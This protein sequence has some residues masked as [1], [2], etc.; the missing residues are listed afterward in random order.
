MKH[1]NSRKLWC[2]EMLLLPIAHAAKSCSNLTIA[3]ETLMAL[4]DAC[5]T[6]HAAFSTDRLSSILNQKD[7]QDPEVGES[8]VGYYSRQHPCFVGYGRKT[9]H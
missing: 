5:L 3:Q 6:K 2:A 9:L 7:G 4:M 1:D 8:Q